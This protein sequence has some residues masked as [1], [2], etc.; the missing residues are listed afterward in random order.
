[1][2]TMRMEDNVYTQNKP[3]DSNLAATDLAAFPKRTESSTSTTSQFYRGNWIYRITSIYVLKLCSCRHLKFI[4]L[5]NVC[6]FPLGNKR[7][8]SWLIP[9]TGG[10]KAPEKCLNFFQRERFRP[11]G[12][13]TKMSNCLTP[14]LLLKGERHKP[15]LNNTPRH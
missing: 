10:C 5:T 15:D 1:M 14:S 8:T 7:E 4:R 3:K 12:F 13:K 11:K 9:V 2:F 6:S